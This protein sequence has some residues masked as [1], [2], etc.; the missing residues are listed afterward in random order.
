EGLFAVGAATAGVHGAN[1]LGGNSLAETVVFGQLTGAHL[2]QYVARTALPPI[3]ESGVREHFAVLSRLTASAGE[4]DPE[5]LIAELGELLWCHAGI[6]RTGEGLRQ[7]LEKLA[8]IERRAGSLAVGGE[9]GER[10]LEW[11]LNLACMLSVAEMILRGAL[12]R[13]E[14]RGAHHRKDAPEEDP[15]WRKSILYGR[16]EE[17][18]MRLWTEPIPPIPEAIQAALDEEHE[19]HYHHLE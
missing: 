12:L 16:D 5:A 10:T 15:R 13:E 11:A 18:R 6:V 14:S 8:E 7:G 1:R 9:D 2:V 17:G 3:S 4:H 19:L